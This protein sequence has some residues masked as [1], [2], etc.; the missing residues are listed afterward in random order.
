LIGEF[1]TFA[2]SSAKLR[3]SRLLININNPPLDLRFFIER[4]PINST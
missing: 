2:G 4:V 1:E 3:V